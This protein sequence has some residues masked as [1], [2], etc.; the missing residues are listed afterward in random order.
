MKLLGWFAI[1]LLLWLPAAAF[2]A[3]S[4]YDKDLREC[5]E[6]S[7]AAGNEAVKKVTVQHPL[8]VVKVKADAKRDAFTACMAA[9]A[10]PGSR[11]RAK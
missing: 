8:D 1:G 2:A 9:R 7:E 10:H 4:K 5:D 6:Q 3:E 11:A